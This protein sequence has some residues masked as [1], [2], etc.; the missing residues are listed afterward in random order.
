MR[1]AYL[2][3]ET[4]SKYDSK[5]EVIKDGIRIDGKSVLSIL[6]L[7]AAQGSEVSVEATGPDAKDAVKALGELLN[8]G[9]PATV[10]SGDANTG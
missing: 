7:G 6:T 2:F 8:S 10:D 3:A 5:I 1:P 4:A 9:F